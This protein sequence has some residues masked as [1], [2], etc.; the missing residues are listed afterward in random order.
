MGKAGYRTSVTFKLSFLTLAFYQWQRL[1]L[2]KS[3]IIKKCEKR[4]WRTVLEYP[5]TDF[6]QSEQESLRHREGAREQTF[7]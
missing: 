3:A 7:I 2:S 1:G 6:N 5:W 4:L